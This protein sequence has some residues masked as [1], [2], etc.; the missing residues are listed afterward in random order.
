M[1][2]TLIHVVSG[3]FFF[4]EAII[5]SNSFLGRK[6]WSYAAQ[7]QSYS[8]TGWCIYSFCSHYLQ[9]NMYFPG[10]WA[11]RG[12]PIIW[13]PHSPD[14]FWLS[15][16]GLQESSGVQPRSEHAGWTKHTDHCSN[17]RCYRMP[18]KWW[19]IG[20][21]TTGLQMVLTVMCFTS[22]NFSACLQKD[23]IYR[24]IQYCKHSPHAFFLIP[25]N[26][27]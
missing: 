22:E 7:Q 23:C 15:S 13:L 10:Q 20:G 24:W 8:S 1:W 12:G 3:P 16:L 21:M 11:R 9:L 4:D 18:G 14:A 26:T 25:Q 6:L 19:A 5:T 17:C 2:C 27:Y